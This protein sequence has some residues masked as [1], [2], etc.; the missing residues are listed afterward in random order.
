MTVNTHKG[1]YCYSLLPFG[2]ASTP[3]I[4]QRTMENILQGLPG[5]TVYIGDILVTGNPRRNISIILETVLQHLEQ[6]GFPLKRENCSVML[7]K[8]IS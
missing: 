6:A 2:I 8:S 5:I 1:L 7:S 3:S 4:F